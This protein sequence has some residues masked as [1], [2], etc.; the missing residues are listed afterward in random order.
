MGRAVKNSVEIMIKQ[1]RLEGGFE[2]GGRI[3]VAE[4]KISI[5][6]LFAEEQ[7]LYVKREMQRR[8]YLSRVFASLPT[9]MSRGSRELLLAF[10]WLLN[11]EAIIHKFMEHRSSPIDDDVLSLYEVG[12][13]C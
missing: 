3:R 9:N 7:V 8:G 13:H 1:V 11:K 10:A 5:F 6:H 2:R 12:I 4:G